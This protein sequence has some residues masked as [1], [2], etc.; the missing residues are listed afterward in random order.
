MGAAEEP[1]PAKF[2]SQ[3]RSA[4]P[5]PSPIAEIRVA[6]E[7][8]PVSVASAVPS[9]RPPAVEIPSEA[10][11][12]NAM[13]QLLVIFVAARQLR[14]DV[15]LCDLRYLEDAPRDRR[16][17]SVREDFVPVLWGGERRSSLR[18]VR[19]GKT[20]RLKG[21]VRIGFVFYGFA[22]CTVLDARGAVRVPRRCRC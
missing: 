12:Q 10:A 22:G 7:P 9:P 18:A 13:K 11:V 5:S 19:L 15:G 8:T 4:A 14:P 20:S 21:Y 16:G 17:C 6:D 1:Q 3:P 2:P